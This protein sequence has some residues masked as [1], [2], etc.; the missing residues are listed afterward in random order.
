MRKLI[1]PALSLFMLLLITDAEAQIT[2]DNIWGVESALHDRY[3][4]DIRV[5]YLYGG[6][7]GAKSLMYES[8]N[9]SADVEIFTGTHIWGSLPVNTQNGPLGSFTGIGDLT[10]IAYQRLLGIAGANISFD[11]GVKLAT[12][13]SNQGDSL[14][15]QYQNGSGTTELMLGLNLSSKN[16]FLG[17]A[18]QLS[19]GRSINEI[20]QLKKGDA[21]VVRGGYTYRGDHVDFGA[22]LLAVKPVEQA[23]MLNPIAQS[24]EFIAIA[25]SDELQLDLLFKGRVKFS[26]SVSLN[27]SL[28][29][30]IRKVD[31]DALNARSAIGSLGLAFSF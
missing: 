16:I 11:L 12:G 25:G 29:L 9:L 23:T 28:G 5:D 20:T 4:N 3:A 27:G 6:T 24:K 2:Y 15:T 22:E 7:S 1:L 13:S 19:G 30:P 21:F 26:E 31:N 18:Y 8:V 14:P 17:I 10:L